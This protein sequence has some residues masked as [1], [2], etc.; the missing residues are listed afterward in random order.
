MMRLTVEYIDRVLKIKAPGG[1]E[2][3]SLVVGYCAFIW[4]SKA[5][6][7]SWGI[8]GPLYRDGYRGRI[9]YL[10]VVLENILYHS[11]TLLVADSTICAL[12]YPYA[13]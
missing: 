11:I 12:R 4:S 7:V 10:Y 9:H 2:G 5:D 6:K 3:W 8:S 1:F 13:Q